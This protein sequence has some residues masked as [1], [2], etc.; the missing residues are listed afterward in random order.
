M[1]IVKTDGIMSF[2]QSLQSLWTYVNFWLCELHD[3]I[4]ICKKHRNRPIVSIKWTH[5]Q[6]G[7]Y[8]ESQ[9]IGLALV[10][11]VWNHLN[12]LILVYF[13]EFRFLD[14]ALDASDFLEF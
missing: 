11:F 5:L 2:K 14:W 12:V 3:S 10:L 8:I 4:F 13:S 1:R 9:I 7:H 6:L